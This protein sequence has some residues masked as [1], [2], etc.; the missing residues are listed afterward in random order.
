MQDI[1]SWLV[2]DG[3]GYPVIFLLLLGAGLGIP[4]PEDVALLA[5]GVMATHENGLS[6][7]VGAAACGVFVLTRDLVVYGLG[8][9]YGT[10]ILR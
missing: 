8:R 5:T 3:R 2:A 1:I 7:P 10:A 9:R 4:I 6:V